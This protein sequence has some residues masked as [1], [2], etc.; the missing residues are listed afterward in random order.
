[1]YLEVNRMQTSSRK[2]AN[3]ATFFRLYISTCPFFFS[4]I[5]RTNLILFSFYAKN[6]ELVKRVLG[7]DLKIPS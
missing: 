3:Y 5:K 2:N 1:M 7:D 4:A 6:S